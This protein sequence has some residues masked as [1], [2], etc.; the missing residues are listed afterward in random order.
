MN[1]LTAIFKK[2]LFNNCSYV[3]AKRARRIDTI[4]KEKKVVGT[5]EVIAKVATTKHA[6]LNN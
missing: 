6:L 1:I 3:A 5:S 4:R 2:V